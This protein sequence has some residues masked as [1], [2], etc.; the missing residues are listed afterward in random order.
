MLLCGAS[1]VT[2]AAELGLETLSAAVR[3]R[4]LLPLLLL[5]VVARFSPLRR[6]TWLEQRQLPAINITRYDDDYNLY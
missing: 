5:V 2:S 1:L 3:S 4:L 6:R